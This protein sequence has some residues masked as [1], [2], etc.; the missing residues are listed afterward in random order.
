MR[1]DYTM[2]KK[3][4]VARIYDILKHAHVGIKSPFSGRLLAHGL[5]AVM[6]AIPIMCTVYISNK[7]RIVSVA[8]LQQTKLTC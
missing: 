8:L 4:P 5:Q 1:A 7:L 2:K 3:T 6:L